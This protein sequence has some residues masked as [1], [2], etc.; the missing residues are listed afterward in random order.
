M[1]RGT[2]LLAPPGGNPLRKITAAAMAGISAAALLAVGASS[3]QA[4]EDIPSDYSGEA[5]A[6]HVAIE[7]IPGDAVTAED[8]KLVKAPNPMLRSAA[9]ST[10]IGSFSYSIGGAT[11]NVPTGCFLTHSIKGS[12]KKIDRQ[13]TGVD[14]VGPAVLATRFCNTRL[15]YHYADTAGKTYKIVRGPLNTTCKTGTVP[16]YKTGKRTLPKYGK[17]CAQLFVNGK[18][19]AVQCHFITK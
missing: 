7:D 9:G 8:Q 12:G 19:R 5:L 15:E 18:R 10:A 14:C 11:F 2:E 16:V 4:A 17:A 3:A 6:D 13:I 1:S